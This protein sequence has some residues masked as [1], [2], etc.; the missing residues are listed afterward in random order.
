MELRARARGAGRH[1][2]RIRPRSAVAPCDQTRSPDHIQITP[3]ITSS[4]PKSARICCPNSPST[5]RSRYTQRGR[6]KAGSAP[7][8][9]SGFLAQSVFL[10]H[11]HLPGRFAPASCIPS[12]SEERSPPARRHGQRAFGCRSAAGPRWSAT[13][14]VL[15]AIGW[16]GGWPS[17]GPL[18]RRNAAALWRASSTTGSSTSTRYSP[19]SSDPSCTAAGGSARW[20]SLIQ[21][22]PDSLRLPI[23]SL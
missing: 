20:R 18:V 21:P 17:T 23:T 8:K 7:S 19:P 3:E 5:N 9:T 1:K 11:T 16:R 6:E 14:P 15:G 12:G 22:Q 13:Q 10:R 4:C 2:G